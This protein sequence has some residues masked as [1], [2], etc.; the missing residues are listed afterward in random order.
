MDKSAKLTKLRL[1]FEHELN[2]FCRTDQQDLVRYLKRQIL[3]RDQRLAEQA[4]NLGRLLNDVSVEQRGKKIESIQI[5]QH[6]IDS[7]QSS[8]V[9]DVF[10]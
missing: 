6:N 10:L 1:Q 2:E 4:D 9:G 7:F 8:T 5:L 3:Q